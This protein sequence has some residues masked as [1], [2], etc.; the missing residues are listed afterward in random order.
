M[1]IQAV[2]MYF[3]V[4]ISLVY[5]YA[6]YTLIKMILWWG[7]YYEKTNAIFTLNNV[8]HAII[9]NSTSTQFKRV[10]M[11]VWRYKYSLLGI[12]CV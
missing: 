1:K 12:V 6:V 5:E 7:K 8:V 11:K 3:V 2:D 4:Y 10:E 9:T